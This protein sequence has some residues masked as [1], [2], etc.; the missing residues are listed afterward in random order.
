LYRS[1]GTVFVMAVR[2]VDEA[3]MIEGL[4]A[5]FR[6]G[7]FEGTSLADIAVAT[8]LQKSS[9]YHRFPG[10]KAQMAADVATAVAGRFAG[11][12]LAPLTGDEP[13]EARIRSVG[14]RLR[15]FY[16]DGERS[17]L[18][19]VLS[20]GMPG[21][22]AAAGLA[23]AAAGWTAAFAAVA[24]EA[25]ADAETATA[26]AQDAIGAIEGALVLARAT[27]D[28]RPFDRAIERLAATLL[29]NQPDTH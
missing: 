7:G 25:G 3:T 17:C 24:R 1:F 29:D 15:A 21:P 23:A 4:T 28:R 8:G 2:R 12:V 19:D 14:D 5:L 16:A 10:G 11:E 27:G 13:P 20:I 9:L 6:A 18:L 22:A 26:R